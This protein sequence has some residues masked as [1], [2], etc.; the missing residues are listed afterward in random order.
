VFFLFFK[1]VKIC[2]SLIA[3]KVEMCGTAVAFWGSISDKIA[4]PNFPAAL[5]DAELDPWIED[6]C[7]QENFFKKTIVVESSKQYTKDRIIHTQRKLCLIL[8]FLH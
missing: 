7:S 5:E 2:V 4:F 6:D 8:F 1:N 3:L